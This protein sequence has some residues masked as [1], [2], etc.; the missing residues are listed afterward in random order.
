[1]LLI[2]CG[3]IVPG[4]PNVADKGDC[5][6]YTGN[7]E[8]LNECPEKLFA[9]SIILIRL[10]KSREERECKYSQY[11]YGYKN[12]FVNYIN[13]SSV[14]YRKVKNDE[15]E[16]SP[17]EWLGSNENNFSPNRCSK[18]RVLCFRYINKYDDK[19]SCTGKKR[20]RWIWLI[21]QWGP[22]LRSNSSLDFVL[23]LSTLL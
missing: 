20:Q 21:R 12:D 1:M 4:E 14:R 3:A 5:R 16:L 22:Q 2:A 7:N 15:K 6:P 19:I 23:L 17:S 10:I 9:F 18:T 11:K 13:W 8:S